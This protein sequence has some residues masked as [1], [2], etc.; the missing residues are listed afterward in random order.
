MAR[1]QTLVAKIRAL[2]PEKVVE[3]E[4]FVDFLR[5]RQEDQALVNAASRMA[6]PSFAEVWDNDEDAIYDEP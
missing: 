4:D 6:E 1:E 3:V 2:P 5:H